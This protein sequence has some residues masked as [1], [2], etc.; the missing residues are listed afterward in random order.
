[1]LRASIGNPAWLCTLIVKAGSGT[2]RSETKGNILTYPEFLNVGTILMLVKA[3]TNTI[4]SRL[5]QLYTNR[6]VLARMMPE[7]VK[8]ASRCVKV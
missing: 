2:A 5:A 4:E 6:F 1:M 3:T 8:W 7:V